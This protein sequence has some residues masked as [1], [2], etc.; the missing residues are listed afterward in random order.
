[1]CKGT[2]LNGTKGTFCMFFDLEASVLTLYKIF[3]VLCV[4]QYMVKKK[5]VDRKK[6]CK[7]DRIIRTGAA[8]QARKEKCAARRALHS[9][10]PRRTNE[11]VSDLADL[12][13]D[14]ESAEMS[15]EASS[16]SSSFSTFSSA[17]FAPMQT[18]IPQSQAARDGSL[19]ELSVSSSDRDRAD[20]ADDSP[21]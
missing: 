2:V 14:A 17:E 15:D 18:A 12:A 11:S 5:T 1:M 8:T 10:T 9:I 7:A 6:Q 19:M 4:S 3:E 13:P 20:S 16:C 21:S